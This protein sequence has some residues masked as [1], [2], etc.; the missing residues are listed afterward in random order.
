MFGFRKEARP[1]LTHKMRSYLY[2]ETTDRLYLYEFGGVKIN[3]YFIREEVIQDLVLRG[4]PFLAR[5]GVTG[6]LFVDSKGAGISH[7]STWDTS[8]RLYELAMFECKAEE[9][10]IKT[11]SP[12]SYQPPQ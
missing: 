5:L 7:S 12:V 10:R 9:V 3:G 8:N 4:L 2:N 1:C 11:N 6:D